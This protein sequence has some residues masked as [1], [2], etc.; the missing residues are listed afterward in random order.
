[1]LIRKKLNPQDKRDPLVQEK[2]DMLVRN[3]L[4]MLLREILLRER[5][6]NAISLPSKGQFKLSDIG[7]PPLSPLYKQLRKRGQ[8]TERNYQTEGKAST[9][10]RPGERRR[11]IKRD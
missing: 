6:S 10:S 7:F 4:D 5:G 1:M 8:Q 9:G 11:Q 2:K 3:K